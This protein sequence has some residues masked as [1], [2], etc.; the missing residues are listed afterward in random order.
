M[1]QPL[2]YL[3]YAPVASAIFAITLIL[4]ILAFY[5]DDLYDKFILQPYQ[6]AKGRRAYTLLTS[7]LIHRDWEHLFFN[8]M[9]Y[10]FFAFKLETIIGHWQFGL[11]YTISLVLSDMPTVIK[12]KKDYWYRSLGASGAISAVVFSFILFFPFSRIGILFIPVSIPA[13]LFGALYLI[14]CVYASRRAVDS[15][16]HDAHFYG[17]I[18]GILITISLNPWIVAAFYHRVA[19]LN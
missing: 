19:A 12:H 13:I 3:T 11:L 5:N 4:S 1:N 2:V 7:G 15:I 14:Y 10:F 6:V 16:N 17:A 8:L 9:S 18:C